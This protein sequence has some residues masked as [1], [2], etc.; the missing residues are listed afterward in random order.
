MCF[1]H[2]KSCLKDVLLH[3]KGWLSDSSVFEN[4]CLFFLLCFF[5][6]IETPTHSHQHGD[7]IPKAQWVFFQNHKAAWKIR[8]QKCSSSIAAESLFYAM[9]SPQLELAFC[10]DFASGKLHDPYTNR[11]P[12]TKRSVDQERWSCRFGNWI[13]SII[14]NGCWV[15]TTMLQVKVWNHPNGCFR[16]QAWISDGQLWWHW[17]S[18]VIWSI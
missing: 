16:F 10:E 15:K 1:S 9:A 17:E 12:Y 5:N 6:L 14:L 4:A 13:R 11:P 8:D 3:A 2:M 7:Q 18:V